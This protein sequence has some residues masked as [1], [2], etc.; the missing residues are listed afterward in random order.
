VPSLKVITLL[1][2]FGDYVK[3]LAKKFSAGSYLLTGSNSGVLFV[4][5]ARLPRLQLRQCWVVTVS[6]T[7]RL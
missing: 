5:C 7:F 4:T 6:M 2:V 1:T 3:G